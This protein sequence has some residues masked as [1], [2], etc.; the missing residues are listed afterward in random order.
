M[1]TRRGLPRPQ[2][3]PHWAADRLRGAVVS[4]ARRRDPVH[5]ILLEHRRRQSWDR[6]RPF[7]HTED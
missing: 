7:R 1:S 2:R 6:R 3:N 4:L 5:R